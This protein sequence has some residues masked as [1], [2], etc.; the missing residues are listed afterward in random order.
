MTKHVLG[1]PNPLRILVIAD[2]KIPVPPS[3]YGGTERVIAQLCEGFAQHGHHVTLMAA[4]G[5]KKYGRLI[6]Y[7]WSGGLTL[8]WRCY[9]KLRFF[10]LSIREL[11]T[12]HDVIVAACRTDYLN[13]FLVAGVPLLYRF[14]NP[15]NPKDVAHLLGKTCGKLSLVAVSETQRNGFSNRQMHTI[16][17]GVDLKRLNYRSSVADG[18]LAF[19]GRLTWN[20]GADIAI[21]VARRTGLPLKIAGTTSDEPG[22]REFFEREIV[23]H[24]HG[25]IEWIGEIDDYTKSEFLGNA[26]ALLVPIRWQEPFG[27]AVAE[28]FA[29]GTPV[30]A[31]SRGS[32]PEL[33]R[34]GVNGFLASDEDEIVRMVGRIPQIDRQTCRRDAEARFSQDG[35]VEK[36]LAII[37]D[38]IAESRSTNTGNIQLARERL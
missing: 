26:K 12:G 37:H 7:P 4:K 16:H 9:F 32:M 38:L 34:S 30:I 11:A 21:R 17:N 20:K 27:L 5:S 8:P 14:D 10:V 33:I 36:H 22:A 24:L 35:M 3:N 23:P 25:N 28:A 29:C 13:P 6:E 2:S 19:L 1:R 31:I 18:Y 15:I